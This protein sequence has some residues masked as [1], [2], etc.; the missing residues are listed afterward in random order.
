MTDEDIEDRELVYADDNELALILEWQQQKYHHLRSL[1]IATIGALATILA[2]LSTIVDV[3]G[4]FSLP[5][6]PSGDWISPIIESSQFHRLT[7]SLIYLLSMVNVILGVGI[8]FVV[9]MKI[10]RKVFSIAFGPQLYPRFSNTLFLRTSSSTSIGNLD[11]ESFS[12][13]ILQ[14]VN[15]NTAL[16][17]RAHKNFKGAVLR[18]IVWFVV[19]GLLYQMYINIAN[20]QTQRLFELSVIMFLPLATL[21]RV[22]KRY[23][24]NN[25]KPQSSEGSVFGIATDDIPGTNSVNNFEPIESR[26]IFSLQVLFALTAVVGFLDIFLRLIL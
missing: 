12:N 18:I 16:L 9:G 5:T 14:A 21:I 11:S 24:S 26:L 17:Q 3:S 22:I 15:Q 23:I 10:L 1:S 4:L 7:I 13:V 25:T 20:T 6:L 2:V 8:L 19:A